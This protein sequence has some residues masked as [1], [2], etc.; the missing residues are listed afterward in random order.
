MIILIIAG[1]K[2]S[3]IEMTVAVLLITVASIIGNIDQI[4]K[5]LK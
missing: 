1:F 2:T 3:S 4:L 5:K